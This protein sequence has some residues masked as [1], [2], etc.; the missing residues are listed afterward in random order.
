MP[1]K[2]NKGRSFKIGRKLQMQRLL[3]NKNNT[4]KEENTYE[5]NRNN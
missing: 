5:S 1:R 2:N 4:T 3:V